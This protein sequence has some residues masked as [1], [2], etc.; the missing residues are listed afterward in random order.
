MS[1]WEKKHQDSGG[2]VFL[3]ETYK[4]DELQSPFPSA[5]GLKVLIY[6]LLPPQPQPAPALIL[7]PYPVARLI[8]PSLGPWLLCAPQAMTAVFLIHHQD[9]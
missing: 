1:F 6:I 8:H 9:G 7:V 4:G 2:S 5:A 3:E